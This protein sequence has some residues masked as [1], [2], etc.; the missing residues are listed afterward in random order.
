MPRKFMASGAGRKCRRSLIPGR[1][2][3]VIG[4]QGVGAAAR[5]AG[6]GLT[7]TVGA[8]GDKP[9]PTFT[10]PRRQSR[11]VPLTLRVPQHPDLLAAVGDRSAPEVA[12]VG[13]DLQA[14]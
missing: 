2:G 5:W 9:L 7:T 11:R 8:D 1:A 3:D 6:L 13:N 10:P 14:G 12:V 4:G